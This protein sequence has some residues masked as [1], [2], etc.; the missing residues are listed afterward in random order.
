MIKRTSSGKSEM[1]NVRGLIGKTDAYTTLV[2]TP[3]PNA[4]GIRGNLPT[5]SHRLPKTSTMSSL[6]LVVELLIA[7]ISAKEEKRCIRCE[8]QR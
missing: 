2:M 5:T 1:Y 7:D 3:I 4:T 6:G 8:G